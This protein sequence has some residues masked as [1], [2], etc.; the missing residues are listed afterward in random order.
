MPQ[1]SA[2]FECVCLILLRKAIAR[3]FRDPVDHADHD[4]D[5]HE[6]CAEEPFCCY[7][8]RRN[9]TSQRDVQA[10]LAQIRDPDPSIISDV[11]ISSI[12]A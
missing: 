5:D 1:A 2:I 4:A 9:P 8:S 12:Q 3:T 7:F 10:V 11:A 6:I